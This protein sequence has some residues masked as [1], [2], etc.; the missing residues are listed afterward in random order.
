MIIM[1]FIN[2]QQKI[3]SILA[4]VLGNKSFIIDWQVKLNTKK[5]MKNITLENEKIDGE[6]KQ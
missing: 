4:S 3:V 1:L 6:Y 2:F 5:H